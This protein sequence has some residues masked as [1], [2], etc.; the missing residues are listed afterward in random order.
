MVNPI[1]L[2]AVPLAFAFSIPLFGFI[3]KRAG[4]FIPPIAML[5]NLVLSIILMPKV[6]E[7]PV[8]VYLSGFPPPFGINLYAGPVGILF[9]AVIALVG[10]FV[11]VYAFGYIREGA[12]EKYHVLYLLLLTGATGAVLTGDIFNLFVFYEILCISSYALVA[13]I[14]DRSGI[15]AA[16]KYLIQGSVGSGL[17]L[18]G[19]AIFYGL[20]GTLNMAQIAKNINSVSSMSVFVPLVFLVTGFGV[21]AAIFPLNAWLPDAHS[22]AP[23]SISAILSGIAIKVGLYAVARF[24]FTI[25]GASNIL[26]FLLLLGLITLL[27]GEMSA[28]KQDNI[29][30]ILAYS[31]VGQLGLIVFAFGIGTSAGISGG[32]FLIVSHALAKSALFLSVGYIIYH[33]GSMGISSMNGIG[34]QMPFVSFAC[35][36]AAFSLVGLPPFVGFPGKFLIVSATLA[37]GDLLFT[38]LTGIV[39]AGTVIEGAYFFRVVQAL[40]FR[41]SDRE[42]GPG[43][44][45]ASAAVP[46]LVL[47]VLIV[48]FGIYPDFLMPFINSAASELLDKVGY[49]KGVLG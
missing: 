23:S 31:S 13:Y 7:R 21:E 14:G 43:K 6:M 40:Y 44:I 25:C 16:V 41:D 29:K 47:V 8:T 18:I 12:Q 33:T 19:I 38:V 24:I 9:S 5:F 11:S 27:I 45:P 10:F 48:A 2:I 37:Q 22:S 42:A 34:K 17:I 49:I 28:F 4:R 1:L 3:S 20:F 39:L 26:H 35:V 32:M 30:R 36:I 15:E 46:I